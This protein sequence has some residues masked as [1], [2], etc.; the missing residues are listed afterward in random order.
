MTEVKERKCKKNHRDKSNK[1]KKNLKKRI[2]NYFDWS[3]IYNYTLGTYYRIVH[4][5]LI[6]LGTFLILFDENPWHL[7]ILLIIVTS[8]GAANIMI[9]DCPLTMYETMYL[10]TSLSDE[11]K[12]MW[13]K[14]KIPFDCEHVYESQL[15]L[16]VNIWILC[17]NKIFILFLLEWIRGRAGRSPS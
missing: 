4:W 9:H 17:A 10:G 7:I 13:K 5:I 11:R 15:E 14:F 12:S 2:N 3:Q 1:P 8:D 16:I 6:F